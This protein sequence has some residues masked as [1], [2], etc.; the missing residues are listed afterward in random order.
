MAEASTPPFEL[1]AVQSTV[2]TA[3]RISAKH[4]NNSTL[5]LIQRASNRLNA[6]TDTVLSVIGQLVGT[7]DCLW[8]AQQPSIVCDVKRSVKAGDPPERANSS[9]TD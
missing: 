5:P 8:H 9:T 3:I 2:R 6:L 1:L 4:R 7:S